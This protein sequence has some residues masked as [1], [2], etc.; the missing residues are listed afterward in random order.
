MGTQS[1]A[2]R[3]PSFPTSVVHKRVGSLN[4]LPYMSRLGYDSFADVGNGIILGEV[5][6]LH[7][8]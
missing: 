3:A 4:Q 7:D 2:F 1:V 6:G 5:I 8:K